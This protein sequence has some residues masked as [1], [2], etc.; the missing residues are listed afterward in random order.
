MA[1]IYRSIERQSTLN[2]R[3]VFQLCL[4]R[5]AND[6]ACVE[7]KKLL[8]KAATSEYTSDRLV[9]FTTLCLKCRLGDYVDET[10]L[11]I[12]EVIKYDLVDVYVKAGVFKDGF[13]GAYDL[14]ILV[15]EATDH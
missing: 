14:L 10:N 5:K 8:Q 12:V 2:E 9:H 7:F 4:V 3:E 1:L 13:D 6:K 11:C 15:T